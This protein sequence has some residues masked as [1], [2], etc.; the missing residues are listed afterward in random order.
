LDRRIKGLRNQH[1]RGIHSKNQ[2]LEDF[3]NQKASEEFE[4]EQDVVVL[5][6]FNATHGKSET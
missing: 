6:E 1:H 2:H 4:T 3:S 5:K